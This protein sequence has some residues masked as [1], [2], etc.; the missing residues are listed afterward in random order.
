MKYKQNMRYRYMYLI[1]VKHYRKKVLKQV[2]LMN[3]RTFEII[4][5]L[6]N[7]NIITVTVRNIQLETLNRAEVGLKTV[8]YKSTLIAALP[9]PTVLVQSYSTT[10]PKR[11][12]TGLRE[13]R[14][15]RHAVL[16]WR[17]SLQ[18]Q[19]ERPISKSAT[20]AFK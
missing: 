8:L 6:T 19:I 14:Y 17:A 15:E 5:W 7:K 12:R 2:M 1:L 3:I 10:R 11:R 18:R 4:C 20:P 13:E 9:Q 16:R